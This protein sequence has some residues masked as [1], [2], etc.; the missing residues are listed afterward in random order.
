MIQISE[1]SSEYSQTITKMA[2]GMIGY[3]SPNG[4]LGTRPPNPQYVGQHP[5]QTIRI[6]SPTKTLSY[7]DVTKSNVDDENTANVDPKSDDSVPTDL[8]ILN[9]VKPIFILESDLF[10]DT[11]PNPQHFLTHT[12]IFKAMAKHI[13]VKHLIG[14]QR[15]RG[16][17]RIYLDEMDTKESLLSKGF[18]LRGKSLQLYTTNPRIS[19]LQGFDSLRVRVKN[20]P[21]SAGDDQIIRALEKCKCKIRSH[22]RERLRID[23]FLTNC[24][25][26]DSIFT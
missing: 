2:S 1:Y 3:V 6:I 4:M 15:V 22:Y 17:W 9:S 21:L 14:L 11:K 8:E 20:V 23:G 26:G 5:L 10:G 16:M 12:E 25:T 18:S 24:Q 7:A 13:H 19:N